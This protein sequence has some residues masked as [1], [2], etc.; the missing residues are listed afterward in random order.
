MRCPREGTSTFLNCV[1]LYLKLV[2]TQQTG[3]SGLPLLK[4]EIE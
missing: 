1:R 4:A 3:S 2:Q